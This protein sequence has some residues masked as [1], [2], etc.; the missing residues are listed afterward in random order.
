MLQTLYT[1]HYAKHTFDTET[2][3]LHSN[4]FIQ[5]SD[6]TPD[7]FRQE[8]EKWAEVSEACKPTYIYDYCVHFVYPISIENQLWLAH[9]LNPTWIRAGVQKYA[10]VVPE[11]F[12]ANLSVDQMFEE[13][14]NMNLPNQ[15]EIKHFSEAEEAMNWL[16]S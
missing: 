8:M 3:T 4:W 2:Q 7:E 13:F 10:H 15:F 11:E 12:I 5:T 9:L 14:F 16:K 1:S 6:M